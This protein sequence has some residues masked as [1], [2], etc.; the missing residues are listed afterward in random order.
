NMFVKN[1][2]GEMVPYSAFM[3]LKKMQGLNE[4][5]RYNLYPPAAIQGAPAAG[6]SSGQAIRAIQ[7]VAAETLLHGFDVGWEGLSYDEAR[8]GNLGFYIFLIGVVFVSLVLVASRRR[9][10]KAETCAPGRSWCPPPPSS[11]ASSRRSSPPAPGRLET[12]P[13]APPR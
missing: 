8:K 13:L 7:E 9:P 5:N 6:Y 11:P 12:A 3:T 2:R 1:E 10:S 4:D